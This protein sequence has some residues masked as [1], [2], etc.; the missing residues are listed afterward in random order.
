MKRKTFSWTCAAAALLLT[1]TCY[2]Q[3]FGRVVA[4]GGHTSD[5]AL[6]EAR[7]VAYAANFTANRIDVVSLATAKVT[8]SMNVASQPSAVSLSPDGRHLVVAHFANYVAPDTPRNAL[9]VIDLTTSGRQTF[10]LADPPLGV[11]FGGDGRAGGHDRQ[12]ILFEPFTGTMLV[13][14][15]IAG[16]TAKTLPQPPASYPTEI[17]A[18]SV[19]SS[20]DMR[21]IAGVTDTILFSYDVATRDVRSYSYVAEPPLGPRTISVSRTGDHW[22]AGWAIFD[23]RGALAQFADPSGLLNIGSHAIDS[24][25]NTIYAQVAQKT[26]DGGTDSSSVAPELKVADADNLRTRERLRLKENLSGKAVLTADGATMY[27]LSESGLTILPVGSMQDQPRVKASQEDLVFR[28]SGCSNGVVTQTI[29]LVDPGGRSTPFKLK[30]SSSGIKLSQTSGTTPASI[31][32]SVDPAAFQ[33]VRGTTVAQITVT[34]TTAVKEPL[35]PSNWRSKIYC[36][37]FVSWYS[38]TRR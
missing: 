15:T 8:K 18:A 20:A 9:T 26:E 4:L 25:R 21:K 3:H 19:A 34:S 27:A 12:F 29:E 7:G 36:A 30:A 16:V 10:A 32:V 22:L 38:S 11:A 33:N 17:V 35:T 1:T 13:L 24:E 37:R 31:Q 28:S 23:D 14:D 6:D 2:G 5:L